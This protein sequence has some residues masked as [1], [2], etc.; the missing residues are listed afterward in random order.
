MVWSVISAKGIGQLYFVEGTMRQEQYKNVLGN[1][2]LP[3]VK[4]WFP[5][6]EEY[7]FMHDSAPCHKVRSVSSF[8]ELQNVRV[9]PWPGNS[10]EMDP[11]ENIWEFV[12][13]RIH[14]KQT[15]TCG[16]PK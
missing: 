7:I 15:S 10:P 3:Q 9:L 11:I 8:F 5:D 2:L 4:E 6:D 14:H 1:C 13:E 12:N 16:F